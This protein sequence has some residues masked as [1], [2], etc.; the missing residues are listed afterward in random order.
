MRI[1]RDAFGYVSVNNL[2]FRKAGTAT[3]P[4]V[5]EYTAS[6]IKLNYASGDS[7]AFLSDWTEIIFLDLT[8]VLGGGVNYTKTTFA[9]TLAELKIYLLG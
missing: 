1:T 2:V 4:L 6:Q 3:C 9:L 8:G 5:I 7:S